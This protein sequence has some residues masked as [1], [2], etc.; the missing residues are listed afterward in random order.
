[1]ELR[2]KLRISFLF[3]S[4]DLSSVRHVA[5][6]VAVMYLG[7]L[8]EIGDIES[9]F[10]PPYHPYTRALLSAIPSPDPDKPKRLIRLKG[11]IPSAK[12]PPSVFRFHTRCPVKIGP[13]CEPIEPELLAVTDTHSIACHI[14]HEKL[15]KEEKNHLNRQTVIP[16]LAIDY[17]NFA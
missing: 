2:D 8:C 1:L 3:I 13:I 14:P 16:S 6:R 10:A 7:K 4:H 17:L 15:A 9:I 5:D 12:S 11:T